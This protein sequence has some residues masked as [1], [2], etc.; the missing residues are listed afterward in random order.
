MNR[1]DS[2]DPNYKLLAS[3]R[4]FIRYSFAQ[5][6]FRSRSVSHFSTLLSEMLRLSSPRTKRALF[7]FATRY[8]LHSQHLPERGMVRKVNFSLWTA[9]ALFEKIPLIR[10]SL[11]RAAY[12]DWSVLLPRFIPAGWIVSKPTDLFTDSLRLDYQNLV[13]ESGNSFRR[14]LPFTIQML[15]LFKDF[16]QA[17]PDDTLY[18]L[19]CDP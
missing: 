10:P 9:R 12:N 14:G 16:P 11:F 2:L 6:G 8:D 5:K 13:P 17:F 18:H 1:R 7:S 15:N 19:G 4:D 3:S